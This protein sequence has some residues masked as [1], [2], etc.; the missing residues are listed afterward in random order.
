ML[1]LFASKN[2]MKGIAGGCSLM[3]LGRC[4]VVYVIVLHIQRDF[5]AF[6]KLF[7]SYLKVIL[8]FL[9]KILVVLLLH[10]KKF[11]N[12]CRRLFYLQLSAKLQIA[13]SWCPWGFLR[14]WA[15]L[16]FGPDEMGWPVKQLFGGQPWPCTTGCG[17]PTVAPLAFWLQGS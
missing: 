5:V 4:S 11:L 8:V 13:K 2:I 17:W 7:F 15:K 6:S 9:R 12:P 1:L 14:T 3:R 10:G 16:G